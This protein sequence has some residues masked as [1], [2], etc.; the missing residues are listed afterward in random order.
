MHFGQLDDGA[1]EFCMDLP[2]PSAYTD[3]QRDSAVP[4][5]NQDAVCDFFAAHQKDYDSKFKAMYQESF[6]RTVK[7]AVKGTSTYFTST[8]WAEMKKNVAYRTDISFQNGIICETQ[9]ECTAGEGPSAHCKHV[10]TTLYA[11]IEFTKGKDIV[12]EQTCTQTLQ[13]FNQVKPSQGKPVKAKDL[14]GNTVT[15][16][17]WETRPEGYRPGSHYKDYFRNIMIGFQT[18]E[19]GRTPVLQMCGYANMR[20]MQDH[21][22]CG[23]PMENFL[24]TFKLSSISA[25]E[26][27]AIEV[28]TR[29][30]KANRRWA[31]EREV[32]LTSSDFGRICKTR[33][34]ESAEKMADRILLGSSFTSQATRHGLKYE[35]RAL[36][37]LS[38]IK[39]KN[40]R[41]CGLY[42]STQF[43]F[44][45]ASPDGIIDQE[46]ACVEVKC[47]YAARN[48]KICPKTVVFLEEN[49]G[50]LQ[51]KRNH[52]YYY[53]VQG[54][55]L[56]SGA[57]TC[58]FCVYTFVDMKIIKVE[59]DLPFI[60]NMLEKLAT[61]YNSVYK[62]KL[63]EKFVYRT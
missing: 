16:L 12:T 2:D 51:L 63:I 30:Q 37:K 20:G 14:P 26:A 48:E 54:Q 58:Y 43:P 25:E 33:D 49:N 4:L 41:E 60:E 31:T 59:R 6:I 39:V 5:V 28:A 15:N 22:Y 10:G 13:S 17:R 3:I 34:H 36:E 9:C 11:L 53:Q 52:D 7:M 50:D 57:V 45:G 38:E 61:F 23:S 32:R 62:A 44:L 18:T 1:E 40:C 29:G 56:C 19:P 46:N 42:I 35:K 47:P 24:K 27:H 8:I 21:D 55:M